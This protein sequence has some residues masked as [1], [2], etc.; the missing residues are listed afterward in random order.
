MKTRAEIEAMGG[1]VFVWAGTDERPLL[2]RRIPGNNEPWEL[3]RVREGSGDAA[4]YVL[5]EGWDP[6]EQQ[7]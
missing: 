1:H 3:W 2:L 5:L 6:T 7:P 4:R